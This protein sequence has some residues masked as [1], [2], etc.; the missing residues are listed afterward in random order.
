MI[1]SNSTLIHFKCA[2]GPGCCGY[3][4]DVGVGI[5]MGIVVIG[6]ISIICPKCGNITVANP[7]TIAVRATPVK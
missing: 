5:Q 6:S 3:E 7:V 1:I 2:G 4:E